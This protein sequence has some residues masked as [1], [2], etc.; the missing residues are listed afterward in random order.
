MSVMD[1]Y[2]GIRWLWLVLVVAC[3]TAIP[4]S[5][6]VRLDEELPGANCP[7]G[8]VAIHS[9]LDDDGDG[10]LSDSEVAST[11]YVCDGAPGASSLVRQEDEG[12]GANCDFGGRAVLSGPDLDGNGYLDTAEVSDTGYVCNGEEGVPGRTTL[13]AVVPELPGGVCAAGGFRVESG[14]DENSNGILEPGEVTSTAFACHGMAGP[15]GP[16]GHESLVESSAEPAGANCANGG[17]RLR[18]GVDADDDGVLDAGEITSTRYACHGDDGG[19]TLVAT[20]AEPAGVNCGEGGRRLQT[21]V[22][23]DDDGTLDPGEVDATSYICNGGGTVMLRVSAAAWGGVCA[24]GGVRVDTGTDDDGDALLDEAEVDRTQYACNPYFVQLASGVSHTCAVV[25]DGSVRCWGSNSSGQLG[26]GAYGDRSMPSEPVVGLGDVVE[27]AA[28][29]QHT[30]AR[31]GDGAVYCWGYNLY[32]QLGDAST[33]DRRA[34]V[35]VLALAA[36]SGISLGDYYS[37]ARL[38]G[39]TVRCWGQNTSGQL[40]DGTTSNRYASVAVSGLTGAEQIDSGGNHSCALVAGGALRC[41]GL[42]TTGQLGD[43]TVMSRTTPVSPSGLPAVTEVSAGGTHTCVRL[44]DASVRCWG[45]NMY[46]Q[47]GDGSMT[48]RTMPPASAVLV[49]VARIDL[50]NDFSCSAMLDGS[51]RCWGYNA[52]GQ[53]GDGTYGAGNHRLSPTAVLALTDVTVVSCGNYHACVLVGTGAAS[54]WGYNNGGQLGNGSGGTAA[55][56]PTPAPV[57]FGY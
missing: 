49:G 40:G 22:D 21:G 56:Y 53:L 18:I 27:V 5:S 13:F 37:C 7:G 35:P 52:Q 9:G 43:G 23:D 11:Q 42:N 48:N 45:A 39:G 41:W 54:C 19:T 3:G 29:Y 25:S 8:G 38:V 28:G 17:T 44:P 33:T 15:A 46:G 1:R 14:L 50:G 36:A 32:G 20:T 4:P 26:I 10:L 30:C 6:V 51:A 55:V 16:T 12:P 2:C 57:G 34:P 47:L 31:R 24:H